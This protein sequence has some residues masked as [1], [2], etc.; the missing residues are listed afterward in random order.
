VACPSLNTCVIV[1]S[2][3]SAT[4]SVAFTARTTDGGKTWATSAP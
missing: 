3:I 2:L 1:G 4:H